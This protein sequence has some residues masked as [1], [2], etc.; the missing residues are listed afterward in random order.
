MAECELTFSTFSAGANSPTGI[1]KGWRA[2]VA[3]QPINGK[4]YV[5]RTA[6]AAATEP[7]LNTRKGHHSII[8]D[9]CANNC[10]VYGSTY[11]RA[12]DGKLKSSANVSIDLCTEIVYLPIP[13]NAFCLEDVAPVFVTMRADLIEF[14]GCVGDFP[15]REAVA[16]CV[17]G[18]EVALRWAGSSGFAACGWIAQSSINGNG[19]TYG[20]EIYPAFGLLR[21]FIVYFFSGIPGARFIVEHCFPFV[22]SVPPPG[23]YLV[24]TQCQ[25][26]P[27]L[28]SAAGEYLA[29]VTIF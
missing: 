4:R 18:R 25:D 17:N 3:D 24:G 21:I 8:V 10:K 2:K 1:R 28:T 9:D 19:I 5:G 7:S 27:G 26:C 11:S 14:N 23:V 22:G 15:N 12:S 20:I 16:D 6:S 29:N 13:P